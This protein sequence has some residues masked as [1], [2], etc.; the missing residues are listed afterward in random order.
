MRPYLL[1]VSKAS[2]SSPSA[3]LKTRAPRASSNGNP[4]SLTAPVTESVFER[5]ER[6]AVKSW[7]DLGTAHLFASYLKRSSG[8]SPSSRTWA[9]NKRQTDMLHSLSPV[10]NPPV[11]AEG[12]EVATGGAVVAGGGAER[13]Y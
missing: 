2:L 7:G 10:N 9:N 12:G 3:P 13:S 6:L 4:V 11:R 5:R 1:T 8:A